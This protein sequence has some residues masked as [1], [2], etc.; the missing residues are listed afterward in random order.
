MSYFKKMVAIPRWGKLGAQ[1][2]NIRM[3]AGVS[4]TEHR[5]S[6]TAV[7][8]LYKHV[9]DVQQDEDFI[10]HQTMPAEQVFHFKDGENGPNPG[11][12]H[13]DMQHGPETPWNTEENWG[14]PDKDDYLKTLL[15]AKYK[16]ARPSWI[17]A[18][19]R[20]MEMNVQ[21]T[22]DEVDNHV[23]A[24]KDVALRYARKKK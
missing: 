13:F 6:L 17:D 8:T 5:V 1:V 23:M 7:H 21:E 22:L 3:K 15:Q 12:L 4:S 24:K 16:W 11:D 9:F 14:L 18:Q 19:P 20:L 10:A 2:E